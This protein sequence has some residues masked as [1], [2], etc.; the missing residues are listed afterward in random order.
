MSD[1]FAEVERELCA[2]TARHAH[3]PWYRRVLRVALL[4]RTRVALVSL[5]LIGASTAVALAASGVIL[6]GSPVSTV[7]RPSATAGEG[8]PVAGGNRLLPLRVP[9]PAGGLPWGMRI[10]HTTRGLICVQVGRVENGQLGELGID[11]AFHDDGLFHPLP[12]DALPDVLGVSDQL[13]SD[14]EMPGATFSGDIVG[15]ELNAAT[16]PGPGAGSLADR[17]EI[18]FGLLGEHAISI[19]YRSG[20]KTLTEPVIPGLGAYLIVQ[21]Y[22]SGRRLG[23]I[24]ETDGSDLRYGFPASPNGALT[25]ITYRFGKL[26]TDTGSGAIARPCG[27]SESPPPHAPPL[28]VVHTAL[29]AHLQIR[30][31]LITGAEISFAAPYPVTSAGED[32]DLSARTCFGLT[33]GSTRRDIA[34]GGPVSIPVID[35]LSLACGRTVTFEVDYTRSIYGLPTPTLIGTVTVHEPPGTH[36]KPLPP[37]LR[38]LLVR[39]RREAARLRAQSPSHR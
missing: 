26:C 6:T 2:A 18:S 19:T 25:A 5:A 12:A 39:D 35:P 13:D 16:N 33:G 24:S 8:V 23:G 9:D 4:T 32:Y 36:T 37:R 10:V 27:L 31:H 28:P 17:R 38:R 11:G 7:E 1:F 14:C 29:H 3:L 21:R 20:S 22:T 15:L 30:G 34:R